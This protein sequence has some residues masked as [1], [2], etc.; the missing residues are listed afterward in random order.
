MPSPLCLV[1]SRP[2]VVPHRGACLPD[3]SIVAH[4]DLRLASGKLK[5]CWCTIAVPFFT[6][7]GIPVKHVPVG[8]P[9]A[10]PSLAPSTPTMYG[11][12]RFVA[13]PV[14][15][16]PFFLAGR[17]FAVASWLLH[18]LCRALVMLLLLQASPCT[19]P[20]HLGQR[21]TG[22]SCASSPFSCNCPA[23]ATGP[24]PECPPPLVVRGGWHQ[25][26]PLP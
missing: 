7:R 15:H 16:R 19:A 3:A 23:R 9:C 6:G 21:S 22:R 25:R 8:V 26:L 18:F 4:L 24:G 2:R 13:P 17:Q 14:I 12:R 10:R 11:A 5:T 20:L 1:L